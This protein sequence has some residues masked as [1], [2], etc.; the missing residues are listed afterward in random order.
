MAE[1][2]SVFNWHELATDDVCQKIA[3]LAGAPDIPSDRVRR[4]LCHIFAHTGGLPA[5]YGEPGLGDLDALA[6]QLLHEALRHTLCKLGFVVERRGFVLQA[7][8]V[9]D[10]DGINANTADDGQL[11]ALPII[12]PNTAEA[13]VNERMTGGP[14]SGA[15]EF[16]DRIAGIG[17]AQM[18][19]LAGSLS[20]VS[21]ADSWKTLPYY[22]LT[23]ANSMAVMLGLMNDKDAAARLVHVLDTVA[24][25]CA[26]SPHPATRE[27][28]IREAVDYNSD[29]YATDEVHVLN[30]ACYYEMV[31]EAI[32]AVT[33]SIDVAMFHIAMPEESHPTRAIL[34][35]LAAAKQRH[36]DVRV[37]VDRDQESDPYNSEIINRPALDYLRER[38]VECRSDVSQRLLH[39]KFLVLDGERVIIGSHNWSAGSYFK[40]DDTS[41]SIVSQEFSAKVTQRFNAMW[42]KGSA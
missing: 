11:E 22:K 39:S 31:Q 24:T 8:Q 17:S 34:D 33:K 4:P 28:R 9:V 5:I 27:K 36:A 41:V 30:G 14:F 35:A 7:N 38:G 29:K 15:S 32:E 40:F 6:M 25:I 13:I 16:I 20:F 18:A 3:A 42:A 37:L 12:G 19:A 2:I 26:D 23:L 1:R 21:P 10:V